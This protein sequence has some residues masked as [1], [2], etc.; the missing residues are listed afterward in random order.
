MS[1]KMLYEIFARDQIFIQHDFSSSNIFFF[2][3]FLRSVKPVRH[4]I[5]HGIFVMLD[6]MLD[7]FNKAFRK[8]L[9]IHRKKIDVEVSL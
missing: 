9:N 7:R 6:E 4:F 8:F 5:E 3:L 1:P 2:F